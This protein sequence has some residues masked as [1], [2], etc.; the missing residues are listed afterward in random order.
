MLVMTSSLCLYTHQNGLYI[1]VKC[2]L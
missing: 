1:L 2:R